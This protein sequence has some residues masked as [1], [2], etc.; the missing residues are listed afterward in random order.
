MNGSRK[1]ST[2]FDILFHY[3]SVVIGGARER[4]I[5]V[6]VARFSLWWWTAGWESSAVVTFG[7]PWLLDRVACRTCVW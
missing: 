1:R 3:G 5:L 6:I 7:G 4:R 2:A